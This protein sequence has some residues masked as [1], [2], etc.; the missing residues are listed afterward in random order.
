MSLDH[1]VMDSDLYPLSKSNI[2]IIYADDTNLLLS[3]HTESTLTLELTHICDWAQ[4]NKMHINIT[5]TKEL[6]FHRP[7]LTNFDVLCTLVGV[8]QE[9][10]ANLLVVLVTRLSFEA[11]VNFLFTVCSQRIYLMKLLGSQ[12]LP[13]HSSSCRLYLL[14]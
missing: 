7:H 11:D 4:Q 8:A 1:I 10:V 12:C 6:V 9:H 3:E 5:K 14:S 2:L 13:A